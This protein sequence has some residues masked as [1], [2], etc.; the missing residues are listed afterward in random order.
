MQGPSM[1]RIRLHRRT[2]RPIP[3]EDGPGETTAA[4]EGGRQVK[5]VNGRFR[6]RHES[7]GLRREAVN[8]AIGG[9]EIVMKSLGGRHFVLDDGTSDPRKLAIEI[10]ND[11]IHP[12]L[13]AQPPYI[14]IAIGPILQSI[15]ADDR[16][17]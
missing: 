17:E 2:Y 14:G 11:P 16:H 10:G 13:L 15:N 1:P 8:R 9:V 7:A 6:S 5:T 4:G 3:T 12:T